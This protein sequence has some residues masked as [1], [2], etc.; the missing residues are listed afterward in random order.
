MERVLLPV[1]AVLM[2]AGA[3]VLH[4]GPIKKYVIKCER[5]SAVTC[6]VEQVKASS[7]QSWAFQLAPDATSFVRIVPRRR[8]SNSVYL[9]LRSADK[10]IFAAQFESNEAFTDANA[11]SER[12]NRFFRDTDPD[13]IKIEIVPAPYIRWISWSLIAV[14]GL[15]VAATLQ[16][17]WSRRPHAINTM[18]I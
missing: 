4:W 10:E 16:S 17:A 13:T 8:S 18:R 11:A 2:A 9:Y 15:F 5:A 1:L 6:A 12:L 14:L 7:P 3:A